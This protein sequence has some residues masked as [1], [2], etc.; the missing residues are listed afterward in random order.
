MALMVLMGDARF[1][2]LF[3]ERNMWETPGPYCETGE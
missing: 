1:D 3:D 2:C